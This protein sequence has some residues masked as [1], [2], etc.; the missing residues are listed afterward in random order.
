MHAIKDRRM[1]L[2]WHWP[3]SRN[4]HCFC[5]LLES[6][7]SEN[8][9]NVIFPKNNTKGS[10]LWTS[11]TESRPWD[12]EYRFSRKIWICLCVCVCVA[13]E[14]HSLSHTQT[15]SSRHPKV[16]ALLLLN[17]VTSFSPRDEISNSTHT[18]TGFTRRP[19]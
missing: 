1:Y 2:C 19:K 11:L 3:L 7:M 9:S 12:D 10:G 16:L 14:L 4:W 17:Q 6:L 13:Y 18:I 5:F 8:W 15:D